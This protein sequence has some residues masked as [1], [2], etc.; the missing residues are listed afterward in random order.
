VKAVLNTYWPPLVQDEDCTVP[1]AGEAY[2]RAECTGTYLRGPSLPEDPGTHI[3]E[4]DPG[5]QNFN[6]Q[7]GERLNILVHIR[8][9]PNG[10]QEMVGGN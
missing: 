1:K 10:G 8:L 7:V 9:T 4:D 6:A 5:A 2:S 3:G